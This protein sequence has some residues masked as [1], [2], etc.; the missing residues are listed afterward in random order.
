MIR[1]LLVDDQTIVREGI[2]NLLALTD[3]IVVVAQAS[4]GTQVIP[5]LQTHT[6]DVILLDIQMPKQNGLEVLSA[7]QGKGIGVPVIVLTTFDDDRQLFEATRLGAKGYLL[8]DVSLSQLVEGVE[9]VAAGETLV[10]PAITERILAGLKHTPEGD[11]SIEP[12]QTLTQ[13]EIQVLRFM[14]GG[15]S[16]KEIATAMSLST[17]TIKNY[18]STILSK[19]G[20]RDRTRA[21]LKAV[22]MGLLG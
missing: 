19:L 6:V 18:V 14:A 5:A 20:V 15:Y 9:K 8:K 16:N 12:L 11:N 3:N 4:D 13:R 10:Q 21:V 7:L 2:A 22:D 17:G 1:V